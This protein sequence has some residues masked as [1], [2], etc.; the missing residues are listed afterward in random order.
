MASTSVAAHRKSILV[1]DDDRDVLDMV[2]QILRNDGFAVDLASGPGAALAAIAA[3][4]PVDLLLTDVRMPGPL[5]GFGLARAAKQHLADL[6]VIYIS[7]WVENL[8]EESYVLGPLLGKPVH[9]QVLC[10]A[11]RQLL[12]VA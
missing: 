8:P 9:P 6:E 7:G 10:R 12:K 2:G 1:V 11:V 5:D 3:G 4:R